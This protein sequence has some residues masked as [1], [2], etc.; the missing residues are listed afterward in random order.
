MMH[1]ICQLIVLL[2]L[3][4]NFLDSLKEDFQQKTFFDFAIGAISSMIIW[5]SIGG[6]LFG[7]GAL[8]SFIKP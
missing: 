8:S 3:S 7:A 2:W 5:G 4:M 1:Q 6:L